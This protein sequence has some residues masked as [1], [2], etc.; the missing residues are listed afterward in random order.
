MTELEPGPELWATVRDSFELFGVEGEDARLQLAR[1]EEEV[2]TPA[3]K[4]WFGVR[5]GGRIV[6]SAALMVF[7]HVGHVDNVTT[8]P[9]ARGRG[10]ATAIAAR[11]VAEAPAAGAEDLMLFA[12]PDAPAVLRLYERLGFREAGRIAATRG[13]LVVP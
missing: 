5:Q 2:L 12:D 7:D 10:F 1:I 11:I 8:F 4:R 3:G 13:P 6:A 9:R